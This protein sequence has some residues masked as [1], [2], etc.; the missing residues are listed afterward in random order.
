[1]ANPKFVREKKPEPERPTAHS[2]ENSAAG[3]GAIGATAGVP[4]FLRS[5]VGG[6]AQTDSEASKREPVRIADAPPSKPAATTGVPLFLRA[7]AASYAPTNPAASEREAESVADTLF[8]SHASPPGDSD[9][10]AATRAGVERETGEHLGDVRLHTG[11]HAS[12]A[13][14]ALGAKAYTAGHDIVFARGAFDPASAAGKRLLA[15]EMTH[16]A[17]QTRN[18]TPAIQRQ[19]APDVQNELAE[20]AAAF[21]STNMVDHF[22][23][24]EQLAT[25]RQG[26]AFDLILARV[27]DRYD[28]YKAREAALAYFLFY[29]D[30]AIERLN[31][32]L[33]G[34]DRSHAVTF[35]FYVTSVRD[36]AVGPAVKR[37]YRMLDRWMEDIDLGEGGLL[38]TLLRRREIETNIKRMRARVNERIR[39]RIAPLEG[40]TIFIAA[41][42]SLLDRLPTVPDAEIGP[43]HS[44]ILRASA[45]VENVAARIE[46][47]DDRIYNL[48]VKNGLAWESDE[49]HFLQDQ[50]L[51]PFENALGQG[52]DFTA[53]EAF[54]L[55]AEQQYHNQA[56]LYQKHKIEQFQAIWDAVGPFP[57]SLPR[58]KQSDQEPPD[59]VGSMQA[60][61]NRYTEHYEA[62][63]PR[64]QL[65]F[66]RH[67]AGEQISP[68]DLAE[69]QKDLCIV[70]L[71]RAAA[72][73]FTQ[74]F[75]TWESLESIEG[76]VP[77]NFDDLQDEILGYQNQ[78]HNA[79]VSGN[80]A[81]YGALYDSIDF[82]TI[83]SRVK[84][85]VESKQREAIVLQI[86]I[87]ALSALAS[88]GIALLIRG[89]TMLVFGAEIVEAGAAGARALKGAEF[90][91]NVA[92]F[93]LI[94]EGLHSEFFGRPVDWGAMPGKL[95][96]NAI[97]FAVFGFVGGRTANI[98]R[99]GTTFVSQAVGFAVRQ[100]VNM[101]SFAG[102]G[103]LQEVIFRQQLPSDWREFLAVSTASY[104]VMA[105]VGSGLGEMRKSIDQRTITPRIEKQFRALADDET[106]VLKGIKAL[107]GTEGPGAERKLDAKATEA[108][109][110]QI[111]KLAQDSLT[112]IDFMRENGLSPKDAE[113]LT[114]SVRTSARALESATIRTRKV[115]VFN[116]EKVPGV[117]P[118]GDGLT[119]VYNAR[120]AWRGTPP[121][122]PRQAIAEP[123]G[124]PEEADTPIARPLWAYR[125]AGY[126]VERSPL[127]GE[128]EVFEPENNALVARFVPNLASSMLSTTLI[129]M[130][131]DPVA[132]RELV[133][134]PPEYHPAI[135]RLPAEVLDELGRQ[136]PERMARLLNANSALHFLRGKPAEQVRYLKI[137]A[138]ADELLFAETHVHTVGAIPYPS[139]IIQNLLEAKSPRQLQEAFDAGSRFVQNILEMLPEGGTTRAAAQEAWEKLRPDL[140]SLRAR[141]EENL[142]RR[143]EDATIAE[144]AARL[145]ERLAAV[146]TLPLTSTA[147]GPMV[148]AFF[149]IYGAVSK[150]YWKG[151]SVLRLSQVVETLRGQN[152]GYVELRQGIGKN[153]EQ[154]LRQ[155]LAEMGALTKA[156]E[157]AP[158]ARII[159]TMTRSQGSRGEGEEA[160]LDQI[161]RLRENPFW[162]RVIVGVDLSGAEREGQ[163][164]SAEFERT[165]QALVLENF[166]E[167]RQALDALPR[168]VAAQ[169]RALLGVDP[170]AEGERLSHDIAR[171]ADN[172]GQPPPELAELAGLNRRIQEALRTV[173]RERGMNLVPEGVLG[174]T[175]HAGEQIAGQGVHIA[176]L[177]ANVEAALNSGTDRIGHGL[178]LGIRLPMGLAPLG[179]RLIGTPQGG[180]WVREV[181]EPGEPTIVEQYTLEELVELE[182]K[183]KDLIQRA[184]K[185]GVTIEANPTSNLVL[186]GQASGS[187]P[188]AE[189]L[190]VNPNLR[191]AVSTDNPA[192]HDTDVASEFA[193][194]MAKTTS[195]FDVG[196]RVFL[197]GYASRLGGRSLT[198]AAELRTQILDGLVRVTPADER[199][200]VIQELYD[201]YG[202]GSP[203]KYSNLIT[204]EYRQALSVYV[205]AVI[206]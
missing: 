18:G 150:R 177:L 13:A 22:N 49:I 135:R 112:L 37:A 190:A 142:G 124:A 101:A 47:L 174:I 127:T 64:I 191:V 162:R 183:R 78:I 196:V 186:S 65:L 145:S 97:M 55:R 159:L 75:S 16:V 138:A 107:T 10:V 116:L 85:H 46:E 63:E 156:G 173:G 165:A 51:G 126:R 189:M 20:L 99:G 149:Q 43:L 93:T 62:L 21:R 69:V 118:L 168:D 3:A 84:I 182:A 175:V 166:R 73:D 4:L 119:Y 157:A 109:R 187:H 95:A 128:I 121:P 34:T 5:D 148:S 184:A 117:I 9:P 59:Q 87:L 154:A 88:G 122:D 52:T 188:A 31:T 158:D 170:V 83:Y 206:Y 111:D 35:V 155:K 58:T 54:A 194:F 57:Y 139:I 205:Q 33:H 130:G 38:T 143:V 132:A 67:A 108:L 30:L 171:G 11:D 172:P 61:F 68:I 90:V 19:P 76:D 197:E 193:L 60:V 203:P 1:M 48:V 72:M 169:V 15:H 114:E 131:V 96:E 17:Q 89:G 192:I 28:S 77:G 32:T 71:E 137:L 198:N 152:V 199:A 94:S 14:R 146:I 134:L 153:L 29:P 204:A 195:R 8:A 86:G 178:I 161:R 36:T 50:V 144:D 41:M 180:V 147:E 105:M 24:L 74:L 136:S 98:M 12:G 6:Y 200:E 103:V 201:R 133:N 129:G 140:E 113:S 53:M 79:I 45:T 163:S 141:L 160:L 176:T 92:S 164:G 110:R 100:G 39:L 185:L 181:R 56:S 40:E 70:Q 202:I 123:R 80:L 7:D 27:E 66:Q 120:G 44:D 102:I 82:R 2:G 104:A 25:I 81:A 167:Y 91:A 42:D 179:F 151:G 23:A 125:E 115:T 106:A 26:E